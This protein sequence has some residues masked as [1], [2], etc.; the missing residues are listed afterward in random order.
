MN[1][2]ILVL[3]TLCLG[4]AAL[5]LSPA[6]PAPAFSKIGGSLND[7]QRDVRLHDNFLDVNA[8]ANTTPAAQF[9]GFTGAEL[10]IWK[11]IVEWGSELH[12]DGTGDPLSGNA[13]GNGT[14]NFD[15]FWAGN[16][17]GIG[18]NNNNIVSS[19]ADCGGGGTLAFTETPISDG[20]RIRFCDEWNWDDGPG[21]ISNRWDIQGVMCH[22]YGHALGLGH[23]T[24]NGA[25][26]FPSGS[27][28]QTS[29]RS[30]ATDDT[31][32]IVCVYGTA[33]VTK[34]HIDATVA[35][36]GGGTLTIYGTNFS[37]S[38]NEVWFTNSAI[39]ATGVDP[40]VKVTG[41]SSNG[42]DMTVFM[43]VG[44]G[45]GD[46]MVKKPGS[47]GSV[48]SN[49]FPTDLVGTFGDPP[50][51]H[52]DISNITPSNIDALIP[53]TAQTITI[54]GVNFLLLT[55]LTLDGNS[56]DVGSY[57]VVDDTTIT[58]D[59]PQVAS[60]GAHGLGVTD[61]IGGDELFVNVGAP[62]TPKLQWGTG[63]DLNVVDRDNGL[64]IRLSG[65]VGTVH[66]VYVSFSNTPSVNGFVNFGIGANFSDLTNIGHFAIPA[67]GVF[68]LN[69]PTANI[70]DPGPGG[71]VLY[72]QSFQFTGPAP[73]PVSNV[74]S[75]NLVQ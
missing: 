66:H 39:T 65:T 28:G 27:P 70:L 34:P 26:M 2:R 42:T 8:N 48:L 75:I 58:L 62:A 17:S 11:G 29:I 4:G 14:A 69:V 16:A 49:A 25:T 21:T 10:A 35:N 44:A 53:G 47:G 68:T 54:T 64:T 55:D 74:Q 57:T 56:I 15:A 51:I 18:T 31:N 1:T 20:W 52:P 13:L 5:L 36:P 37:A 41:V 40:I 43:P 6:R 45:P 59:M 67:S 73:F 24:V 33:S 30:I 38:N 9:P 23:S 19:L 22:E 3:P 72:S 46:V 61:G 63:D 12:G 50:V 32:G 7:T 71:L 60:L